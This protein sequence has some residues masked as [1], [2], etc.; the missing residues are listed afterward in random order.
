MK[1][2]TMVD[3]KIDTLAQLKSETEDTIDVFQ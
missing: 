2:I 3:N 1:Q